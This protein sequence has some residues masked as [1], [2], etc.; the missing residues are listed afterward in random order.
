[1]LTLRKSNERG[2]ARF[3]WLDSAHTFSF[4]EYYDPRHMGFG[5]LRVINEDVVAPG[6]GFAT[7]GHR[8]M[9]IISYVLDGALEHKDSMGNGSIIQPGDVQRMSAGTGVTH[10]EY[11]HSKTEPV[12]F[13]QI[14]FLPERKGLAPGYEQKHFEA[15]E[16]RGRLRLVASREGRDG[17]VS[18]NQ[19]VDMYAALLDGDETATHELAAGRSAWIQLARGSVSVNGEMLEAGDGA[20]VNGPKTLTISDARNAELILFDQADR[21]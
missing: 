15:A 16:K 2:H 5:N 18:L 9:E 17:S 13:L 19:D 12:R 11:N 8:D 14:W 10:S 3:S 6:G 4:G 7:H 20:A 21:V 1:M